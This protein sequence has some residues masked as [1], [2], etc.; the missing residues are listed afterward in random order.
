MPYFFILP[1]YSILFVGLISLAIIARFFPRFRP[2]SKYFIGGAIGTLVGFIVLNIIV[3]LVGIAPAWLAQKF[4]FPIWL[5]DVGK[6]FVAATLL[7]GPF[8]GSA[9]GVILGFVIGFYFV[10]KRN[11]K[12]SAQSNSSNQ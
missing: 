4:T 12:L 8:I 3:I 2:A 10:H 6:Y 7:I 11:K 5:H 9:I 1:A